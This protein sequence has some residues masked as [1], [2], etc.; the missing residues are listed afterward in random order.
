MLHNWLEKSML[1]F[2]TNRGKTENQSRLAC[3][4]FLCFK[5]AK[6]IYSKLV[7]LVLWI[8]CVLCDWLEFSLE[9]DIQ[10]KTAL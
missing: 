8:V 9:G 3:E 6:C 1:Y 2:H 7:Q 4:C 10:L 5:S